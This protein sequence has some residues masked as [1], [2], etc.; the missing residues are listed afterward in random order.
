VEKTAR[1][2]R[3][4]RWAAVLV[5]LLLADVC[6]AQVFKWTDADGR[7]HYGDKPPDE[8][9]AK[10]VGISGGGAAQSAERD[11]EVEETVMQ[12]YDVE[13]SSADE[14]H[15]AIKAYGPVSFDGNRYYATCKWKIRWKAKY[16]TEGGRCS[17]GDLH[18]TVAAAITFP[19]WSNSSAG[20][21]GLREKW[22][23]M[24]KALRN[25]EDGHKDNGVRGANDLAR[26]L[27]SLPA[28]P[29]CRTLEQEINANYERMLKVH[30]EL[31]VAYDRATNHGENQ[32]VSLF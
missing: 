11:V 13:G 21:A 1:P 7:V 16:K 26:R 4:W 20:T 17:I 18:L 25:H 32:G 10:S 5:F 6:T 19:R 29:D 3:Q 24:A 23:Q 8:A 12:Y 22:E 30:R 31:D 15:R 28:Q 14:L 2:G 9:K 27:R